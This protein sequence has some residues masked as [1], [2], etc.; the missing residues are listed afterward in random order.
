MK[1]SILN[2][3]LIVFTFGAILFSAFDNNGVIPQTAMAQ[4]SRVVT[5]ETTVV[6][7]KRLPRDVA[8]VA[9]N[10]ASASPSVA[11][12]SSSDASAAWAAR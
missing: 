6:A 1:D 2:S 7:A 3:A 5:T 4:A 8:L 10:V 12:A 11:A 9:A